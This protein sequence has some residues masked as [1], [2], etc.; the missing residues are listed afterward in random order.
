MAII[1]LTNGDDNYIDTDVGNEIN[2]LGGIDHIVGGGGDDIINGGDGN[3]ILTGGAGSDTLIG[4]NGVDIFV[5]SAAGLNGDHIQ[6]LLPGDRIQFTDLNANTAN[7][8]V[9]ETTGVLTYNLPAGG[10]GSVHIDNLGPGRL[11]IRGIVGGGVE[12]RLQEAA[13]NDFNGSGRSD[14]L[15]RH[16]S[17]ITTDWLGQALGKLTDNSSNFLTNP[18]TA[19]HIAGTGD[20][21][22]DGRVDVIWR[23]DSGMVTDWLGTN[24]GGFADNSATFLINPGA[25][26]HIAG[27]DD[28]NG[29]GRV[30]LL[31][32]N[33]NGMVLNWLGQANGG[34]TDNAVNSLAN[35]GT[36]W[37][38]AA[39]GDFNGDGLADILWRHDSG[40]ILDWLGTTNGG[41]IDNAANSFGNP[42]TAWHVVGTGDFNGDG[43]SDILWRHDSGM[44]LNWLGQTNGGFADN[45]GNF[46]ANPGTAWHVASI[47]DYNGDAIDDVLW[48][49]N[50]GFTVEW[51]GQANGSLADNSSNFVANPGT[52]WHVADPAV[53]DPFPFA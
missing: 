16:S 10:Q 37:Q 44:T 5:D 22:G 41:F 47:G 28:V 3:D 4:G 11:V 30:D 19:W 31:W 9:D 35:P 23:H 49:H 17:G 51:L 15:W 50:N 39:T 48:Q 25:A 38:I 34:F 45:S 27:L 33:D 53:H 14:V 29:D 26:W 46:V 13:H 52:S 6:D 1:N 36:A 20:I 2:G 8:S 21:N 43:L 32:R 18:G 24:S 42:G 7:I 12:V 40:M